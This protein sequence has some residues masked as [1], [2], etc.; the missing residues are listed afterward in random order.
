MCKNSS[1]KHEF[2]NLFARY[3]ASV[4]QQVIAPTLQESPR[5]HLGLP[6]GIFQPTTK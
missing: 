1:S 3:K 4:W 5:E 6:K 2:T